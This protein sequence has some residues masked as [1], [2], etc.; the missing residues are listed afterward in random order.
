MPPVLAIGRRRRLLLRPN[1]ALPTYL[2]DDGRCRYD[3]ETVSGTVVRNP[4]NPALLGLR[5][6]SPN[7]WTYIKTDGTH[8]VVA[9]GKNAGI[10]KGAK[11]DFGMKTGEFN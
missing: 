10:A 2:I 1:A 9:P 11:I 6:D 8:L 7:N 5:N 3:I 4:K